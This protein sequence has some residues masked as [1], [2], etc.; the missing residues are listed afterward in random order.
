MALTNGRP[1]MYTIL[2]S[3]R[4]CLLGIAGIPLMID[5]Q[6]RS[7]RNAVKQGDGD[8]RILTLTLELA[9][10][11]FSTKAE[12]NRVKLSSALG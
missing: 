3:L 8:S 6:G 12:A 2:H 1:P 9:A 4:F 10:S 7:P 11:L 5:G